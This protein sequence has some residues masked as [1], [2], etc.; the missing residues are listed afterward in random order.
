HIVKIED[1]ANKIGYSERTDEVIEPRISVQ[2][3]LRMKELAGPALEVVE[4]DTVRFHPSK[5]KNM[6]RHWMEHVQ[7]WCISRQLWWGQR[8]PAWYLPDGTVIVAKSKEEAFEKAKSAVH[9]PQS[10]IT[11]HVSRL[12]IH[13]LTQDPD[14]M[15]TWFSSWL[16]PISVFDGIRKPDNPDINY[17]YPT[18]DLVTAPEIIFFWVARMIMAGLEYRN[19]IPFHNV[20]FTGI[21]RD[22][23]GRKMSKSLGN[24]PEPLRLIDQHGADAVRMGMLLCSPAGNDLLF[25]EGLIE[26]GR[27]FCNKLWNAFRLVKG[28][29]VD[30][31]Q[32]Q[33]QACQVSAAWFESQF[34]QSLK[35]IEELF[36]AYRLSE[37]LMA[38]YKLFWDDFCSWY[39]EMIKPGFRQ[40]ID[41]MTFQATV[42][43]FD[44]LL[45]VLHPFLPFITEEIW[46]RLADREQGAS[47][48][49]AP[50]PD[51]TPKSPEGGLSPSLVGEGLGEG[52]LP[53]PGLLKSFEFAKEVVTAIRTVRKEKNIAQKE[54]IRMMIKK[55][56]SEPVD[57]TFDEVVMKLCGIDELAYVDE[58]QA[59]TVSFVVR[60]TE[61]YIPLS[62]QVD[63]E[64]ELRKLQEELAYTRGFL[65]SVEKKLCNERFVSNA[66]SNV[67][68]NERKKKADAKARIR[69]LEEQLRAHLSAGME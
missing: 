60:T 10:A 18:H 62:A 24:S 42:G 39:L 53:D 3:F 48:M 66:P 43:F 7:D 69:V 26:Q 30:A 63:R 31:S 33:T 27:N 56:H 14:V 47:I 28:W 23:T 36:V 37:V 12:T 41:S 40:P 52:Y 6:Y 49:I 20:Y 68:E 19:E 45:R 35:E 5:Y 2:W 59:G 11:S 13:D 34:A 55:N 46:Q 57:V 25:D 15:D 9:S 21:V 67:V 38:I 54:K 50:I 8:I 65:A 29:E 17:Y 22:K 16:W 58:K 51:C 64:E 4:N 61:F 32:G 44:E 1:Y